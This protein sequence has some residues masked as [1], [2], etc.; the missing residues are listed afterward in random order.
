M[1]DMIEEVT[2]MSWYQDKFDK[3]K[4]FKNAKNAQNVRES[5]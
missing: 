3:L 4:F 2:K 5:Y 1:L